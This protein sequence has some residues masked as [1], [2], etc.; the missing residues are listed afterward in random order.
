M[1]YCTDA[2]TD[3]NIS[4]SLS[5]VLVKFGISGTTKKPTLKSGESEGNPFRNWQIKGT[6]S[7]LC[8]HAVS[9]S[10]T[11]IENRFSYRFL[12]ILS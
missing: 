10:C 9:L 1:K 7:F 4:A 6:A 3:A 8:K 5:E 2:N 11:D 12:G